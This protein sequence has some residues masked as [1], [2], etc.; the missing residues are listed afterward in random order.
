MHTNCEPNQ[1]INEHFF[2]ELRRITLLPFHL[3]LIFMR[4]S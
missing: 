1:V 2:N 4:S 3:Q